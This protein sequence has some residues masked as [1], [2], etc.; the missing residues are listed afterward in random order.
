[1]KKRRRRRKRK[2]KRSRLEKFM[3]NATLYHHRCASALH[4]VTCS[5]IMLD[6][7]K[8]VDVLLAKS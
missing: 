4:R 5:G 2:R 6:E 8:I 3:F 1:M 7:M